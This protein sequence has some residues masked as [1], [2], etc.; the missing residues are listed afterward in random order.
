MSLLSFVVEDVVCIRLEEIHF[1]AL[2]NNETMSLSWGQNGIKLGASIDLW[3]T[4]T[5]YWNVCF[6]LHPYNPT[7]EYIFGINGAYCVLIKKCYWKQFR[8]GM[9]YDSKLGT[10]KFLRWIFFDSH[11]HLEHRRV[12]HSSCKLY[13]DS[14][15]I[16]RSTK[17]RYILN[18][19]SPWGCITD[20]LLRYINQLGVMNDRSNWC[21]CRIQT[22]NSLHSVCD[23]SSII[24]VMIW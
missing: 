24:K 6:N 21:L 1:W 11:L 2:V 19:L 22:M 9:K 4:Y 3:L 17:W 5:F 18:F 7:L 14:I 16:I 20:L 23:L 15:C 13:E 8:Q 12:V 10:H